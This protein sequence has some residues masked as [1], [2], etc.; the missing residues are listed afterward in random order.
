MTGRALART[1]EELGAGLGIPG[2]HVLHRERRRA[3]ERVVQLLAQ[4]MRDVGDLRIGQARGRLAALHRVAALEERPDL[5]PIP[6]AQH[7]ERPQ[8]V[9]PPFT[10]ACLRAVAGDAL[11][12]PHRRPALGGDEIDQ[13]LVSRSCGPAAPPAAAGRRRQTLP[14]SAAPSAAPAGGRRRCSLGRLR[15]E[16]GGEDDTPQQHTA[17]PPL[18]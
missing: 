1:V 3:P 9:R 12:N 10:A 6:I 5:A 15:H 13:R 18:H 4:E 16:S 14:G 2:E 11:G 17:R 8:Q 7:D